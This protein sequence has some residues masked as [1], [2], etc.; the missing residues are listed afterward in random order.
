METIHVT[1][2]ELT[3]MAS[4]QFSSG[5]GLQVLN[6]ATSSSGLVPNHIPQQPCNQPTRNYWDH[7]FQPMFDEYF[8][9][10]TSVVSPVQVAST[11][12]AIDLADSPVSTS[13]DQDAPSTSI[14]STQEQELLGSRKVSVTSMILLDSSLNNIWKLNRLVKEKPMESP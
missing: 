11:P 12:R 1:F 5:P 2:D 8:N 7:L 10:P 6:P 13:I 4:E 14:P 3:T 9:P